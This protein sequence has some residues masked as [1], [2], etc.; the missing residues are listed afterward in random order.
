MTNWYAKDELFLTKKMDTNLTTGLTPTEAQ[1]RRGESAAN[2]DLIHWRPTP[3][4]EAVWK[5]AY[6]ARSLGLFFLG[7]VGLIYGVGAEGG[8]TLYISAAVLGLTAVEIGL[9][10]AQQ[11]ILENQLYLIEQNRYRTA[12]VMRAGQVAKCFPDEIVPGDVIVLQAGDYVP[13]DARV[14]ESHRLRVNEFPLT[15]FSDLQ[16]KQTEL[17][18]EDADANA[19]RYSDQKNMVFAGTF[20]HAGSGKAAAVAIGKDRAICKKISR[21]T[22]Q[23]PQSQSSR[24][25]ERIAPYL[26]WG[27]AAGGFLLAAGLILAGKDSVESVLVGASL[28]AAAAPGYGALA[29]A[30]M[31]TQGMRQLSAKGREGMIVQNPEALEKLSGATA[32]CFDPRGALTEDKVK[33]QLIMVDGQLFDMDAVKQMF[34]EESAA[35][36]APAEEE[37][38]DGAQE[39]EA[40]EEAD[41]SASAAEEEPIQPEKPQDIFLLLVAAWMCAKHSTPGEEGK[42]GVDPM[43]LDALDELNN[44]AGVGAERYDKIFLKKKETPYNSESRCQRVVF[45]KED[46]GYFEFIIGRGDELIERSRWTQLNGK[47]ENLH[48]GQREYLQGVNRYLQK[49]YIQTL[50][51]AYRRAESLA[52]LGDSPEEMNQ[53]II[54]LGMLCFHNEPREDI[55]RIIQRCRD[56]GIRLVVMSDEKASHVELMARMAGLLSNSDQSL[57]GEAIQKMDD[58]NLMRRLDDAMVCSELP[59]EQ[60][61]RIIQMLQRKDQCVAFIGSQLADIPALEAADIGLAPYEGSVDALAH[62]ADALV[63]DSSLDGI[64]DMLK[65]AKNAGRRVAWTASWTYSTHIG[66]AAML[67]LSVLASQLTAAFYPSLTM[68]KTPTLGAVLWTQLLVLGYPLTVMARGVNLSPSKRRILANQLDKRLVQTGP[69]TWQGILLGMAGLLAGVWFSLSSQTPSPPIQTAALYG[70]MLT[71]TAGALVMLARGLKGI[72]TTLGAFLR[73]NRGVLFSFCLAV[74]AAAAVMTTPALG[75]L[76]SY[77]PGAMESAP[78]PSGWWAGACLAAA[79][80]FGTTME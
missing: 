34:S 58:D 6:N 65:F 36:E 18:E 31:F 59:S 30:V 48:T 14:F 21:Q 76:E 9:R 60:K 77:P 50:T 45:E 16:E 73:E 72:D 38:G 64:Y 69:L 26:L 67:L 41:E 4:L 33:P 29:A 20:V 12:R 54:F 49:E 17:I 15:G 3:F 56:D 11:I 35:E 53:N 63:G 80:W 37:I 46:G 74:G 27:G 61:A 24:Q 78:F 71:F 62:E 39:L 28:F 52:A 55:Q 8:G 43:T 66:L 40:D 70:G 5:Q 42:T 47:I 25:L 13:A 68:P 51:V 2:E 79:A 75:L 32:L 23:L 19:P 1:R 57:T 22:I 7:L 10:T 44:I